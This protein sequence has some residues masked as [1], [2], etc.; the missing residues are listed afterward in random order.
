[1]AAIQVEI[2]LPLVVPHVAALAAHN[3]D[4]KEGINVE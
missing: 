1:M 2:L 4:I 3:V